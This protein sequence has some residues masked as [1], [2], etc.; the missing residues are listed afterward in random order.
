[1]NNSKFR[2]IPKTDDFKITFKLEEKEL[3]DWLR[4][5]TRIESR[6]ACIETLHLIQ[7]LNQARLSAA[8]HH[9][10]LKVIHSYLKQFIGNMEGVCWDAKFP[11]SNEEIE[12]AELVTWN[13][14]ALGESFF[15]AAEQAAK[16]NEELLSLAF[17]FEMLG[18][19][20]LHIA[21]IY[22]LPNDGFWSL[23]YKVFALAEKNELLDVEI[24]EVEM[25][26]TSLKKLF[27]KILIFQ[28]CDNTQF[29]P[30]DMRT[31]FEFLERVCGK[32]SIH[33]SV[34]DINPQGWYVF[35]L[36]KDEPPQLSK[37]WITIAEGNRYFSAIPVAHAFY[38]LIKEGKA[39]VKSEKAVNDSL[40]RRVVK[41]L[42]VEHKRKYTRLKDSHNVYGVIGF[43]NITRFLYHN[44]NTSVALALQQIENAT[45]FSYQELKLLISRQK[46]ETMKRDEDYKNYFHDQEYLI[47]ANI[48][49][50]KPEVAINKIAVFDSSAKGYSVSWDDDT[51]K[52]KIGDIFGIISED[53]KRLEIMA[54]RRVSLG[55]NHIFRFG[56]EIIGFESE[57][58][59]VSKLDN[60]NEGVWGI[61]I[62]G[63]K[64]LKQPDT[65]IYSASRFNIGDT[66]YIHKGENELINCQIAAQLYA[67][68]TISHI[69]ISYPANDKHN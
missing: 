31:I 20:Q 53:K 56:V 1:M 54:I 55:L 26:H 47:D 23:V 24:N 16:D 52:V 45:D 18:E 63:I 35:D 28:L 5:L 59:Y 9:L 34:D 30:R 8:K 10:F 51:A 49:I 15:I 58:V 36:N 4:Q 29:R 42:G 66:V 13:Y 68:S 19:A 12:Y 17:A 61:F 2:A 41:T 48:H 32:S 38:Q 37:K 39:W 21:A 57:T 25:K 14:L 44:S 6:Q 11:L 7:F 67:T 33:Q 40:F 3:L 69:E 60:F 22:A 27:K 65:L 50:P 62:P 46:L 64:P 43:E